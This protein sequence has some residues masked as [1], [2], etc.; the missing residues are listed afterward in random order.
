MEPSSLL[1]P[2]ALVAVL[3]AVIPVVGV[4]AAF[5]PYLMPKRECFAV[6]VPDYAQ[7]D[8]EVRGFKRRY[9]GI[10]LGL[11]ALCTV[12]CVLP[13]VLDSGAGSGFA[14]VVAV[15][16]VVGTLLLCAASYGLMLYFRSKVMALKVRRGWVA[17]AAKT[18]SPIG[19]EA[20]PRPLSL[21]WDLLFLLRIGICLAVCL[22]GYSSIPD[23]IPMKVGMDGQ[24]TSYVQKSLLAACFPAFAVAFI[25]GI[26][27]FSHWRILH[28]K[29]FVDP[30]MPAASSWAYGMFAR[31]QSMLLVVGGV[32]LGGV[33]VVMG[34]SFVGAMTLW[35]AAVWS[36]VLVMFVVIGSLAMSVV[37]GQNGSR[38]IAEVGAC[39]SAGSAGEDSS[40]ASDAG[41]G[42][43][44]ATS[45]LR[46]NDR[47]WKLGVFYFNREDPSLF[48]PGRFGIGWTM[49]WARPAAWA[50][51][52]GL[53]IVVIA[54]VAFAF[55]MEG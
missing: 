29:R 30:S 27:A 19:H 7:R 34:L 20:V 31:A 6:T 41:A 37:Y 25:D 14:S 40:V 54:M 4:L 38:L 50:V 33:G 39:E 21:R 47:Y 11:A 46:D 36:L 45:L 51:L 48:L 42:A 53:V 12:A 35:Q 17:V 5:M 43:S 18:A 49:N 1:Y 55:A 23:Q 10:M 32:L 2:V 13:W 28:S 26:L 24:V 16:M 22:L 3:I 52:A 9:A 44:W 15:V 8:P